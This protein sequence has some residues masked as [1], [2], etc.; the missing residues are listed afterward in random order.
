MEAKAVLAVH[1][2]AQEAQ[3]REDSEGHLRVV[4][5]SIPGPHRSL[6]HQ[7]L[8]L[9]TPFLVLHPGMLRCWDV[10]LSAIPN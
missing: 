8:D 5:D 4:V 10:S 9:K 1:Q 7:A 2:E 3:D 6:D